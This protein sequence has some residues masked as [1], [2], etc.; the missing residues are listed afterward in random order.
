MFNKLLT[1]YLEEMEER[2]NRK[3]VYIKVEEWTVEKS[4]SLVLSKLKTSDFIR[5]V[6]YLDIF[7]LYCLK[8]SEKYFYKLLER[9]IFYKNIVRIISRNPSQADEGLY[10][11]LRDKIATITS[12]NFDTMTQAKLLTGTRTY[13]W[14][15][16]P[17]EFPSVA[18]LYK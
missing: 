15:Q 5:I 10:A 9:P 11:L 17:Q 3:V 18:Q 1:V 2:R 14:G 7:S 16:D 13:L 8:K 6:E 4:S 12:Y